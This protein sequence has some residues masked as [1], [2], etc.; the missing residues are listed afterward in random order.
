MIA[1]GTGTCWRACADVAAVRIASAAPI[2]VSVTRL[3]MRGLGGVHA[4]AS[5][6][7][8]SATRG[9]LALGSCNITLGACVV[10]RHFHHGFFTTTMALH[11]P[12]KMSTGTTTCIAGSRCRRA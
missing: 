1:R 10:Y 3:A 5:A 11:G 4:E 7:R 2:L 6:D 9:L 12:S 8:E